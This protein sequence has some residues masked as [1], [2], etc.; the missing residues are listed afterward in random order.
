MALET[1]EVELTSWEISIDVNLV[2]KGDAD[3]YFCMITRRPK[4]VDGFLCAL[5]PCLSQVILP[6]CEHSWREF[7]RQFSPLLSLAQF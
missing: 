5:G 2:L 1:A 7:S 3:I 4:E 6:L